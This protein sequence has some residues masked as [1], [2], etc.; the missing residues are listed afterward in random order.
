MSNTENQA[1]EHGFQIIVDTVEH[2]VHDA[3]VS[4]TQV[5][6]FA[7]PGQSENPGYVFKVTY[8]GAASEPKSGILPKGDSVSVKRTGTTFGVLR[9]L[10]S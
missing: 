3:R 9:S 6:E 8:E 10:V 2:S 5:V 7:Y 1:G 4:W